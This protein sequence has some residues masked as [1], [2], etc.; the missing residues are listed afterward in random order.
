MS[1]GVVGSF[2]L[3]AGE[4]GASLS[5]CVGGG[6]RYPAEFAVNLETGDE[7]AE[8]EVEPANGRAAIVFYFLIAVFIHWRAIK[9]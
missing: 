5:G 6:Q 7:L 8:T 4:F 2:E 9:S 1:E 3:D